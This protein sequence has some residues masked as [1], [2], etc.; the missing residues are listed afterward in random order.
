MIV[1]PSVGAVVTKDEIQT[2][3]DDAKAREPDVFNVEV[4]AVEAED[5]TD[6]RNGMDHLECVV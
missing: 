6:I 1:W 5:E 2:G 4:A 3:Y